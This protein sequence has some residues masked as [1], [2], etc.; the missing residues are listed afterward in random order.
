[1][2]YE[3][4]LALCRAYNITIAKLERLIGLGNGTICRWKH[5]DPTVTRLKQV[6]DY[7]GVSLE[8][9]LEPQE[10]HNKKAVQ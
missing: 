7:F 6:A 5:S 1:M 10:N 4:I 9:L 8:S 2:I 3:N